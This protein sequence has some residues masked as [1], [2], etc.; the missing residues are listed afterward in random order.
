MPC[1]TK[2]C[3]SI[4]LPDLPS[5]LEAAM[6]DHFKTLN[7]ELQDLY[8]KKPHALQEITREQQHACATKRN[9][10]TYVSRLLLVRV[11]AQNTVQLNLQA[12]YFSLTFNHN[13]SASVA[14][15]LATMALGLGSAMYQ[16]FSINQQASKLHPENY[17]S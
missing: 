5:N 8:V 15:Q 12:F 14:W 2:L 3:L 7:K 17:E 11:F 13:T 1:L 6:L 16:A 10:A 4:I 9:V